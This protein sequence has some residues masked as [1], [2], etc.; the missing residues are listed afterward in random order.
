MS[1]GKKG[2]GKMESLI[3]AT[4]QFCIA[5][6]TA[7]VGYVGAAEMLYWKETRPFGYGMVVFTALVVIFLI[8]NALY[9][10]FSIS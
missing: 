5:I 7:F 4:V 10:I 9:E 2:A 6:G 3:T 8:G 1:D